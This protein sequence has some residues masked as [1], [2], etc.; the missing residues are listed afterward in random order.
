MATHMQLGFTCMW[1]PCMQDFCW[2]YCY[3]CIVFGWRCGRLSQSLATLQVFHSKAFP[4]IQVSLLLSLTLQ[5]HLLDVSRG[6]RVS[7]LIHSTLNV[8]KCQAFIIKKK[9]YIRFMVKERTSLVKKKGQRFSYTAK[10]AL[11]L[12]LLCELQGFI[13][14]LQLSSL[15]PF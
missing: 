4:S 8:F 9:K 7:S 13:N 3:I 14:C 11:F 15:Q 10:M 2:M 6:Q 1:T 12:P 5:I